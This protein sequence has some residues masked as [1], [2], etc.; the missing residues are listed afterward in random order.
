MTDRSIYDLCDVWDDAAERVE[1]VVEF[2]AAPPLHQ[3]DI[4]VARPAR[5]V[6]GHQA[7]GVV[8]GAGVRGARVA[9]VVA[10]AARRAV[11]IAADAEA[12]ASQFRRPVVGVEAI[13]E[14]LQ[15]MSINNCRIHISAAGLRLLRSDEGQPSSAR[16]LAIPAW[17]GSQ[18]STKMQQRGPPGPATNCP[19]HPPKSMSGEG[20]RSFSVCWPHQVPALP[21]YRLRRCPPERANFYA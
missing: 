5:L 2:P 14:A 6:G 3:D 15:A 1:S 9:V 4:F 12:A 20:T 18:L 16:Q 17:R 11:A 19:S 10:A 13:P 21:P 8:V 7:G